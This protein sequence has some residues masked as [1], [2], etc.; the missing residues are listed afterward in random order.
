MT[1]YNR[2][3]TKN[4]KLIELQIITVESKTEF[5]MNSKRNKTEQNVI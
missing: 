5:V 1:T 4:I 2:L 3:K